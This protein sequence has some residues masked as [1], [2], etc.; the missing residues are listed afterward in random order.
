MLGN[1]VV[2]REPALLYQGRAC[3]DTPPRQL[4]LAGSSAGRELGA[5]V[6]PER[7]VWAKI[8][9]D[10]LEIRGFRSSFYLP[11]LT[12]RAQGSKPRS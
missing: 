7:G 11:F 5:Q 3:W 4:S 6:V 8:C 10:D 2:V 12:T 1:V 9:E